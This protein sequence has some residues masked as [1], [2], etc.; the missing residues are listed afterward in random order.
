MIGEPDTS[1]SIESRI[2]PHIMS[3]DLNA[4]YFQ[5]AQDEERETEA[6]KCAEATVG[7]VANE[8]R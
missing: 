4:A 7:D 2:R 8:S 1:E 3:D 6:L 5:M